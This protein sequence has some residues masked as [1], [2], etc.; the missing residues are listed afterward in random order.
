M[1]PFKRKSSLRWLPEFPNS[2]DYKIGEDRLSS[3]A[4]N[5]GEKRSLKKMLVDGMQLDVDDL[6]NLTLP[7]SVDLSRWC[8]PVE[9][10]GKLN[11]CTA[12][13]GVSL[14]EYCQNKAHNTYTD[15]SRL[16][17]YKATRNLMNVKGDSGAF[18]RTTMEAIRLFGVVPESY[19][20]Y[21]D[22]RAGL[23]PPYDEEPPPFCYQIADDYKAL[24]CF[25]LDTRRL[26]PD[27]LLLRIKAVLAAGLACIFGFTV[28]NSISEADDN[29]GFIAAPKDDETPAGGHS[30]MAVGYDR[31]RLRVSFHRLDQSE[32]FVGNGMGQPGLRVATL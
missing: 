31:R 16:F 3:Q 4:Q 22:E 27:D 10:Q 24:T 13:A 18:N 6:H 7:R 28:F 23:T 2:K 8:S 15:G 32:E 19:W 30:I 11:S 1:R 5:A 21:S 26:D 20:P 25:R 9:D 29:R 14:I 12:N 17:L